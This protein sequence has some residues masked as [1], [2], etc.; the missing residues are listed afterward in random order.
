MIEQ[1]PEDEQFYS[2]LSI[3]DAF[4]RVFNGD[5]GYTMDAE[6]FPEILDDSNWAIVDDPEFLPLDEDYEDY[7]S[8]SEPNPDSQYLAEKIF[9]AVELVDQ[10]EI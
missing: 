7:Q 5:A 9:F 2:G 1:H 3:A 8:D 4:T 6:G 10:S